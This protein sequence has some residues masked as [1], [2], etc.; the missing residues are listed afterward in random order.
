M[1]GVDVMIHCQ[2]IFCVEEQK[3]MSLK[4]YFHGRRISLQ[5]ELFNKI[6]G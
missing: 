2:T 3:K 4:K 5:I 6:I 1:I